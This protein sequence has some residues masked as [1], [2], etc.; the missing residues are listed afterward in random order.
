MQFGGCLADHSFPRVFPQPTTLLCDKSHLITA[1][2]G[3]LSE[4]S[5]SA[6]QPPY[7][8]IFKAINAEASLMESA[9][10]VP[11]EIKGISLSVVDG[12]REKNFVCNG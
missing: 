11:L 8:Y 5:C 4:P 6:L 3:P 10:P 2:G 9:N 12:G 7:Y 1:E